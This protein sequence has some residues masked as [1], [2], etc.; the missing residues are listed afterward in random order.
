MEDNESG[1]LQYIP[2]CVLEALPDIGLNQMLGW[3]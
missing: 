1:T 3:Q 2:K